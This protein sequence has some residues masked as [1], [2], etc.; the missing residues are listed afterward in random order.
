MEPAEGSVWFFVK[1]HQQQGPVGLF[2]LKKLFEQ[3]ILTGNSYVWNK[4]MECWQMAKTVDVLN[5]VVLLE[6]EQEDPKNFANEWQEK[7]KDTYPN[8]QPLVRY[9]ARLFDLS[10]FSFILI[11]FVSIFS[12]NFIFHSSA[13]FIYMLSLVLYILVEAVILSIFGN[14]L[15]KSLLNARVKTVN[16]EPMNFFT[17][18]KRSIFVNAAGMGF[19][20]PIINFFCFL[21]SYT[22]LKKHGFSTWDKQ[23]GTVVLYGQVST[24]RL[25]FAALFPLTL[26]IAGFVI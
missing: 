23:L 2:E 3:Q 26:L 16:G 22:D 21:F 15:G 7:E 11:T 4:D 12:P 25:L 17:A 20:V 19:G 10:L 9:L 6:H 5:D 18:L 24:A 14:T 8:G 1:D 13:I